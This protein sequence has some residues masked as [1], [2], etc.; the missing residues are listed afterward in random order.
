MILRLKISPGYFIYAS[1]ITRIQK[2]NH[3]FNSQ[4]QSISFTNLSEKHMHNLSSMISY[5]V[6]VIHHCIITIIQLSVQLFT[7]QSINK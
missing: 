5:L 1:S 6:Q 3:N 7:K 4:E 2:S